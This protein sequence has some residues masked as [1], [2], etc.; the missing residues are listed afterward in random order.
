MYLLYVTCL[1]PL[2]GHC[3]KWDGCQSPP[4]DQPR[5]A[6]IRDACDWHLLLHLGRF[7]YTYYE[8]IILQAAKQCFFNNVAN[9]K[10]NT[11]DL[12]AL[13]LWKVTQKK[14]LVN[15]TNPLLHRLTVSSQVDAK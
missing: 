1:Q 4:E 2:T 6:E 11:V 3:R 12:S 14:Y 13:N 10:K 9:K 7:V 8:Q 5:M 15:Q